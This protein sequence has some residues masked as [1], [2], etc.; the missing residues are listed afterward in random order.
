MIAWKDGEGCTWDAAGYQTGVG[1]FDH[2]LGAC[3]DQGWEVQVGQFFWFHIRVIDHETQQLGM[4]SCLGTVLGK[5]FGDSVPDFDGELHAS[6]H[7]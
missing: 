5:E 6:L 4:A 2:V 3:D 1:I 7:S